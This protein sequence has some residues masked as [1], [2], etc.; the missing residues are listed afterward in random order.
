MI[1]HPTIARQISAYTEGP[2]VPPP[3]PPAPAPPLARAANGPP[4]APPPPSTGPPATPTTEVRWTAERTAPVAR[5]DAT[6]C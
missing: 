4:P 1:L 6:V 5:A 3:P 2:P